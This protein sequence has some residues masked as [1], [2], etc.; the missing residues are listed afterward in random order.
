VSAVLVGNLSI[1]EIFG[2]LAAALA[3]LE[4]AIAS[5]S[6]IAI[7]LALGN[8]QL[9]LGGALQAQANLSL[10]RPDPA[11]YVARLLAA[12]G[13]I[14][15]IIESLNPLDLLTVN[16]SASGTLVLGLQLAI[17]GLR[18][19]INAA[20]N[21]PV[22]VLSTAAGIFAI[23]STGAASTFGTDVDAVV[24]TQTGLAPTSSIVA[25]TLMVAADNTAAVAGL[26]ALMG[27]L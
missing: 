24:A 22:P 27:V 10:A 9:Q 23:S 20:L 15:A 19:E 11:A 26:Q 5:G 18:A 6:A 2:P 14:I 25:L 7:S 1:P 8:L 21:F 4:A 17:A 16:V 12:A 3:A 13:Q